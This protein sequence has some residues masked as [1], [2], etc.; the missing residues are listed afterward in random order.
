MESAK[1]LERVGLLHHMAEVGRDSREHRLHLPLLRLEIRDLGLRGVELGF[2]L[3]V[4][5]ARIVKAPD[6]TVTYA[7][8]LVPNNYK[9]QRIEM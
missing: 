3:G 2:E 8:Q 1:S 4:R 6:R 5:R 7:M 9:T